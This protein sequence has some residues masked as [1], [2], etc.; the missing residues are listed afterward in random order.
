M[1]AVWNEVPV[2]RQQMIPAWLDYRFEVPAAA[3]RVGT[4]VLVLRF[5][6]APIYH[7]MRGEGPREVRPAAMASIAL[8]RRRE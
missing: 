7:R 1:E 2:G 3:V 8:H 5:E 4:K 6:R